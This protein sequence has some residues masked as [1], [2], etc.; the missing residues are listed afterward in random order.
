MDIKVN[1]EGKDMM[2]ALQLA[3]MGVQGFCFKDRG[4]KGTR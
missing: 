3:D 2:R 1:Q 4:L